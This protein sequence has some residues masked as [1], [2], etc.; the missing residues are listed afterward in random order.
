MTD[1]PIS[2]RARAIERSLARLPEQRNQR[3]RQRVTRESE[4][5]RL[6]SDTDG[7]PVLRR[8]F[9][10]Y[11]DE[12]GTRAASQSM[13]DQ[14][15][16]SNIDDRDRLRDILGDQ[17]SP[18]GD[19][20]RVLTFSDNIVVAA[21]THPL[22]DTY[23]DEGQLFQIASIAIYLLN[24]AVRRRFYRGGIAVG[25][26]YAA[27]SY[28]AGPALIE[29]V[30][31]EEHDA[32][33]PRVLLA[34]SST[35]L[36]EFHMQHYSGGHPQDEPYNSYVLRDEDGRMF[37]NYLAAAAEEEPY[38]KGAIHSALSRHRDAVRYR[39]AAVTD[40]R[41]QAKYDWLIGYHNWVA[42]EFFNASDMTMP[43]RNDPLHITRPA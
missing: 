30:D 14:D 35:A 31:A 20:E 36:A 22:S 38:L 26:V 42:A 37:V 25:L 15:L 32:V 5:R 40:P 43:S 2:E 17:D 18:N 39:A 4:A 7:R 10:T 19:L 6:Y 29:A 3:R 11:I 33:T 27:E 24:Q 34:Q 12:L 16:R 23:G 13:T 1:R 21:P 28:V 9:V 8:S 41:V